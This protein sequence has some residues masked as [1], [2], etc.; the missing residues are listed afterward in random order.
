MYTIGIE[1]APLYL[2]F[3]EQRNF[4]KPSVCNQTGQIIHE[5]YSNKMKTVS[6]VGKEAVMAKAKMR[7][8][9]YLFLFI[10]SVALG[11]APSTV[12]NWIR[13][14]FR[15]TSPRSTSANSSSAH[16][17]LGFISHHPY[18]RQ[19]RGPSPAQIMPIGATRAML[20]PVRRRPMMSPLS[21]A[22]TPLSSTTWKQ[23]TSL[24]MSEWAARSR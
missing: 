6:L 8:G 11:C 23:L 24:S 21:S 5:F 18:Y 17:A 16:L 1:L 9:I 14:A 12:A 10:C 2:S 15:R 20:H 13:R 19:A 4:K 22:F 3:V 7:R